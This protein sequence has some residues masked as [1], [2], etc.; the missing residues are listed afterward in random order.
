[1]STKRRG[2]M[3]RTIRRAI[4]DSGMSLFAI[5]NTS[6]VQYASLHGYAKDDRDIALSTVERLC[7]TLGLE[8]VR[9]EPKKGG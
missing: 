8:L 2:K 7:S 4:R 1:M 3:D 5:S 6:G 9:R